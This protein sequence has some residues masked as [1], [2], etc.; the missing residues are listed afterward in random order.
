M[1]P[2]F[3]DV[4]ISSVEDLQSAPCEVCVLSTFEGLF[5][6]GESFAL[7]VVRVCICD[8]VKSQKKI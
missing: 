6:H 5:L 1:H 4:M 2:P 3:S 8:L 7:F